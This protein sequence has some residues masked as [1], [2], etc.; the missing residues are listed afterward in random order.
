VVVVNRAR[1]IMP[2]PEKADDAARRKRL[3]EAIRAESTVASEDAAARD[4]E[5]SDSEPLAKRVKLAGTEKGKS[6]GRRERRA[7]PVKG[8]VQN[9]QK[10]RFCA[11]QGTPCW[12]Q[13][14]PHPRGSCFECA[15]AKQKCPNTVIN[16]A[17]IQKERT[18]EKLK[19][20]LAKGNKRSKPV[21]GKSARAGTS[22]TPASTATKPAP[23]PAPVA[24]PSKPKKKIIAVAVPTSG[25][26]SD[27][28][29]RDKGKGK[30]VSKGKGKAGSKPAPIV[31]S[32]DEESR[33]PPKR[34]GTFKGASRSEHSFLPNLLS[35]T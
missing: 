3:V 24:G 35:R 19:E 33:P 7:I 18:M 27:I 30:E 21:S 4:D 34:K 8:N 22:V 17:E 6:Q 9:G 28:P 12:R 13:A 31:L 15:I 23:A 11:K 29:L 10:C 26:E 25:D 20:K 16:W 5:E 2:A 32:S 14:G 1:V